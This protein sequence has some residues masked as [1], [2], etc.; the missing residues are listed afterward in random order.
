M[1]GFNPQAYGTLFFH[2]QTRSLA[3]LPS[4]PTTASHLRGYTLQGELRYHDLPSIG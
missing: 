2:A 1:T 4:C 3:Y